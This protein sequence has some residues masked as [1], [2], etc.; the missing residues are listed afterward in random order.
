MVR[1]RMVSGD[2]LGCTDFWDRSEAVL[3]GKVQDGIWL[4][5]KVH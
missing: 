1:R 3:D 2:A 5:G 4:C